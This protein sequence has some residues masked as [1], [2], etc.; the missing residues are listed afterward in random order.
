TLSGGVYQCTLNAV[1]DDAVTPSKAYH[2]FAPLAQVLDNLSTNQSNSN[3]T[4]ARQN[5]AISG[6]VRDDNDQAIAGVQVMLQDENALLLKTTV[7][8]ANGDFQFTRV[9][10]GFSYVVAP[11]NTKVFTFASQNIGTLTNNLSFAFKGARRKYTIS[12]RTLDEAGKA[13]GGIQVT[14]SG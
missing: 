11:V 13:I 10:A 8:G 7:T 1:R 9:P 2:N 14:L 5:Y 12:G 3:F 4:A 6:Q